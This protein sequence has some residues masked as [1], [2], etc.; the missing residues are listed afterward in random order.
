MT[1]P[2]EGRPW[3]KGH[4]SAP[5][6]TREPNQDGVR[7]DEP[8]RRFTRVP[9]HVTFTITGQPWPYSDDDVRRLV[10]AARAVLHDGISAYTLA[11]LGE[12]EE[13]ASA[14]PEY[15]S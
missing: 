3:A 4:P 7:W 15:Q 13:A 14:F 5:L 11:P 9:R 2:I 8:P 12:L 10:E 1:E 6:P